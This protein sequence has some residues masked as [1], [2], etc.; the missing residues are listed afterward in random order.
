MGWLA[1][2][3]QFMS[4]NAFICDKADRAILSENSNT[5]S[6]IARQLSSFMRFSTTTYSRLTLVKLMGR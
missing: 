4:H 1:R 2:I 5:F 6:N 3:H